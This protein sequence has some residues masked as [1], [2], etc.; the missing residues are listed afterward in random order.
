MIRLNVN[1]N[2]IL[3]SKIFLQVFSLMVAS[4][5]W[6][7]VVGGRDE[8]VIKEF[9]VRL[10]FSNPPSNLLVTPSVRTVVVTVKGERRAVAA[11]KP[12]SIVTDVD[13]AGLKAGQ[14]QLPVR[15]SGPA[16]IEIVSVSPTSVKIDLSQLLERQVLVRVETPKDMP[17]GYTLRDQT[18]E[19]ERVTVRGRQN[20]IGALTHVVVR[21]TLAQLEAGGPWNLTVQ[22][23]R[24]FWGNLDAVPATVKVF[25]KFQ[26]GLPELPAAVK[27]DT[28]GELPENLMI[29]NVEISP[30]TVSVTGTEGFTGKVPDLH[31]EPLNLDGLTETT[32][33]KLRVV[34]PASPFQL[35]GEKS[36]QVSVTMGPRQEEKVFESVPL[37]IRQ[38]GTSPFDGWI[39]DPDRVTVRVQFEQ[40]KSSDVTLEKLK[41]LAYVDVTNVVTRNIRVPVRLE[42]DS[43]IPGIS[44]VTV[45]PATVRVIAK[46]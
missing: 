6:F 21:P 24:G 10:E 12:D 14:V 9:D 13:L 3:E 39:A 41:A 2:K 29:K 45:E 22:L 8:S 44:S 11:M 19:P 36:V 35:V 23:P 20:E 34:P 43:S 16:R 38:E 30:P 26:K 15:V 1:L 31:T 40:N 4:V 27:L 42:Y 33:V 5:L 32:S 18:V 25:G 7:F 28:T 46:D 37:E 17:E